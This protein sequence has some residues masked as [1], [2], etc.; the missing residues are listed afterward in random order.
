MES[1]IPD[2]RERTV[3]A[4]I[5]SPRTHERFLRRPCGSY[6]AA[7][8]DCLKDGSTPISNLVLSGDGVFPGI[9]EC[10][11]CSCFSV[12]LLWNHMFNRFLFLVL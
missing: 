9:G 1:V 5:G 10:N 4:L 2:A 6:G 8:E 12:L 3:L 7:F 11:S